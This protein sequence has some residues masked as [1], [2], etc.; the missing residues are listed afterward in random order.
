M[1]GLRPSRETSTSH[2]CVLL[3]PTAHCTH[4]CFQLRYCFPAFFLLPLPFLFCRTT[5]CPTAQNDYSLT[6]YTHS[7]WFAGTS[8]EHHLA[9]SKNLPLLPHPPPVHNYLQPYTL[10][11]SH[12]PTSS[13]HEY[14]SENHTLSERT[15][16]KTL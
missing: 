8:S 5:V 9:P 1:R 12:F 2:A 13:S 7:G 4:L 3:S 14:F 15:E 11:F 16:N 6:V 10:L